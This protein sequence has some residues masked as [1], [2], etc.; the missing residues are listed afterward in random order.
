MCIPHPGLDGN[1][2]CASC[3]Y[4]V[5]VPTTRSKIGKQPF[6]NPNAR[7]RQQRR[8]LRTKVQKVVPCLHYA[9][10]RYG[11][12]VVCKDLADG[13][14][15]RIN[16]AGKRTESSNLAGPNVRNCRTSFAMICYNCSTT[17]CFQVA[18]HS[19]VENVVQMFPKRSILATATGFIP[20]TTIRWYTKS[21]H[22]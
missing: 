17:W 15:C 18:C 3:V 8:E 5:H 10:S 6:E 9:R 7:R 11:N 19:M 21:M 12:F 22:I 2:C 14:I 4:F 20:T 13:F 1:P 16:F